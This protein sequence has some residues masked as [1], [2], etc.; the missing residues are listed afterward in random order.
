M[1]KSLSLQGLDELPDAINTRFLLYLNVLPVMQE[2]LMY[3]FL[4]GGAALLVWSV[5]KVLSYQAKGSSAI[6][7]ETETEKRMQRAQQ[8]R[9]ADWR[10]KE[11]DTYNSLLIP[12]D[13][14]LA[15]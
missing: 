2:V 15:M 13:T 12:D 10:T 8:D 4:A 11:M 1:R 9:Q 5:V 3:L 14:T 7:L 6:W